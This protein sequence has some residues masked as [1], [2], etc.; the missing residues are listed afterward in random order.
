LFIQQNRSSLRDF[1]IKCW[2]K[3]LTNLALEPLEQQIVNVII[4]HPEYQHSLSPNSKSIDKDYSAELGEVNPFLHMGLHL[5][6]REQV[7][8]NRPIGIL[9]VFK[10]L[11]EKHGIE[12]AEHL[13][14][15]CLIESMWQSQ[16]NGIPPDEHV[17][18]NSIKNID[19]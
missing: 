15:D 19:R 12:K 18:L 3:K 1:Y 5:A 4:E 8:T 10:L 17:Y 9:N 6:I 13:I 11:K 16:Q 7:D 2:Q 14:M